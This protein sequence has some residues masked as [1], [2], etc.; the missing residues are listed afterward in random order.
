MDR[1][2]IVLVVVTFQLASAFR[3]RSLVLPSRFILHSTENPTDAEEKLVHQV[4]VG[5]LP[6]ELEDG[7]LSS[8]VSDKIGTPFTTVRIA[9]DKRSGRSRGFGYIHFDEK[10]AAEAAALSLAGLE[11][12]GREVRV[13]I[14]EPRLMRP[15]MPRTPTEN[16]VFIGNLNFDITEEA[17]EQLCD[18]MLGEGK[19]QRVRLPMNRETGRPKGY[20]HLDFENP[21]EAANAISILNGVDVMGRLLKADHA[22]RRDPNA[23]FQPR[24]GNSNNNSV[25]VGNLAW[26]VTQEMCIEMLNDVLGPDGGFTTV[27][28]ATDRETGKPRGFGHIDFTSREGAERAIVELNGMEVLGRQLRAD[29][30]SKRN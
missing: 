21:E 2:A 12:D 17:I 13:D 8:M 20:G 9:R 25:F 6:F 1:F 30:A 29:F 11:I 19:V 5:N 15:R 28:L 14:S 7:D 3:L 27:R 10:D 18:D 16:S 24:G 4:F 22:Q 23:P 26:D